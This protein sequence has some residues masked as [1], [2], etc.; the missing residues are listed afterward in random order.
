MTAAAAPVMV[1]M[2]LAL[3]DLGVASR[4][5]RRRRSAA[6][7]DVGAEWCITCQVNMR[8]VVNYA[9]GRRACMLNGP[10]GSGGRHPGGGTSRD[11]TR[12]QRRRRRWR[13]PW[14]RRQLT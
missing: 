7:A 14:R 2:M 13:Q 12:C 11:A 5:R 1:V 6:F 10:P 3:R 9:A 8:L 4:G